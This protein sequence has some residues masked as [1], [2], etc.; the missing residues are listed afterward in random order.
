MSGGGSVLTAL[1]TQNAYTAKPPDKGSFPLDHDGECKH[2]MK[3]YLKCLSQNGND[4]AKCRKESMEYLGCR[5][6]HKL[7]EKESWKMLGYED[8]AKK[9]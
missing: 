1:G 8:L 9:T 4:N 3:T 6:D 2:V 5:M 7:M